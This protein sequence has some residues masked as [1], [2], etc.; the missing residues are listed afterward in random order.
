MDRIGKA[1]RLA[2]GIVVCMQVVPAAAAGGEIAI[3]HALR[4]DSDG[5]PAKSCRH[6]PHYFADVELVVVG[7]VHRANEPAESPGLFEIDVEQ[8]WLGRTGEKRLRFQG[9]FEAMGQRAIVGLRAKGPDAA[10]PFK[11]SYFWPAENLDTQRAE[12]QAAFDEVVLSADVIY[13][14][15]PRASSDK[16]IIRTIR[17]KYP[18][19]WGSDLSGPRRIDVDRLVAGEAIPPGTEVLANILDFGGKVLGGES[20]LLTAGPGNAWLFLTRRS[21]SS[22]PGVPL[23]SPRATVYP[24]ELEEDIHAA[25]ARRE[26]YP[27]HSVVDD[28]GLPSQVRK[29]SFWGQSTKRYPTSLRRTRTWQC[30][31][32]GGS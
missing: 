25:L 10:A 8:V 1:L 11:G 3:C 21:Q 5:V 9:D 27:L 12:I 30:S 6:V 24:L 20:E 28:D 31:G 14:G 13:A 2:F 16:A 29:S 15:Q 17:E 18:D 19:L 32:R 26:K 22:F 23:L 4:K 7:P